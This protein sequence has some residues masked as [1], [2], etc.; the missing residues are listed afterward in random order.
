MKKTLSIILA[1]I[2]LVC[3]FA[4]CNNNKNPQNPPSTPAPNTGGEQTTSSTP[5]PSG[6]ESST[7]AVPDVVDFEPCDEEVYTTGDLNLRSSTTFDTNDNIEKTVDAGTKLRRTGYHETWSKV[8]YEE[9]EYFCSTSF[10]STELPADQISFESCDET[11]YVCPDG[12]FEGE[13][14]LYTEPDRSKQASITITAKT[15]VK[16]TGVYY[17]SGDNPEKLG[18]SRIVYNNETYY[19]RN[20]QLSAT[21]PSTPA[22]PTPAE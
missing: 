21:A 14:K 16:R 1:A 7:P 4:S 18:W 2:V 10:L 22:D 19:I 20:S 13:S 9:V 3:A 11:L 6:A 5:A 17:E 8:I 12:K 15:E